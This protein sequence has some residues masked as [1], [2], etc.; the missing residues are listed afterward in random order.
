MTEKQYNCPTTELTDLTL[1]EFARLLDVPEEQHPEPL[2]ELTAFG[3]DYQQVTGAVFAHLGKCLTCL[4]TYDSMNR[5]YH[6]FKQYREEGEQEHR[7][8]AVHLT[9]R[10]MELVRA[11]GKKY[12]LQKQAAE[13]DSAKRKLH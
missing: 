11:Y 8:I 10:I 7:E 3:N 9:G 4:N 6:S 1:Y 5:L 12:A 13:Y 2:K